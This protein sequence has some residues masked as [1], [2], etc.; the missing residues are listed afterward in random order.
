MTTEPEPKDGKG[1][2]A[3]PACD[4]DGLRRLFVKGGRRFWR[5][6]RCGLQRLHPLPTPAELSAY[7]EKSYSTG[8]YRQFSEAVDVKTATAELR[9][10]AVAGKARPG[11]WLDVGCSDGRFVE[12][13][14]KRGMTCEGIDLSD[15]VVQVGKKRGLRLAQSDLESWR[16]PQP[17]DTI[18]CFDVLEHVL[19]P[20]GFLGSARRLLD[21]SGTLVLTVPNLASVS[22]RL[23]GPDWYMYIPEE[24]LHYFFPSTLRK[25]LVRTGF[26]PRSCRIA[27]KPVTYEYARYQFGELNPL[28]H[29]I[30]A[31][32]EKAIPF[33]LA[34]KVLPVPVGEMLLIAGRTAT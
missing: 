29:R 5:C 32:F 30:M 9:F 10:G 24:H 6:E 22:R 27:Y 34:S 33:H 25:L 16:P 17:Y 8:L 7:Y 13:A 2:P 11:R 23:M 19:D 20:V 15:T 31:L 28:L 3:C 1:G 21:P 14:G 26:L 18:T 4:R 12:V